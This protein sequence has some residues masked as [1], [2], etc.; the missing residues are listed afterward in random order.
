MQ[1]HHISIVF[2]KRILGTVSAESTTEW[3]GLVKE[4][5]G[6]LTTNPVFSISAISAKNAAADVQ[7]LPLLTMLIDILVTFDTSQQLQLGC[8]CL[9]PGPQS[10]GRVEGGRNGEYFMLNN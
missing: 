3:V 5:K 2:A 1:P 9:Q 8:C 10:L 7:I 4:Q 6:A